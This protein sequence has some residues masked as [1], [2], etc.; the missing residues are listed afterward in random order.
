MAGD[1]RLQRRPR[2]RS[3]QKMIAIHMNQGKS[4]E[5]AMDSPKRKLKL[6]ADLVQ[7]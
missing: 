3:M 1:R 5:N 7:I 4:V 6:H 2:Q